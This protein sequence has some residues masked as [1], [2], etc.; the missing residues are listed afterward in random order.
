MAMHQTNLYSS[1]IMLFLKKAA[2]QKLG[3]LFMHLPKE[4]QVFH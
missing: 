1:Y 4:P 2:Q 3:L